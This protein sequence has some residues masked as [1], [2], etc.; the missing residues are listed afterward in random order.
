MP[1]PMP[2]TG[3]RSPISPY[4]SQHRKL[5]KYLKLKEFMDFFKDQRGLKILRWAAAVSVR[6]RPSALLQILTGYFKGLLTLS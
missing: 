1:K 5:G 4:S 6:V 3:I 2:N